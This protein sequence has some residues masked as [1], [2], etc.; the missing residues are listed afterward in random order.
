MSRYCKNKEN[1]LNLRNVYAILYIQP[2]FQ[3][4]SFTRKDS[5]TR[6]KEIDLIPWVD[7]DAVLLINWF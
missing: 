6:K 4:V 1:N 3:L 5:F 7:V 2:A